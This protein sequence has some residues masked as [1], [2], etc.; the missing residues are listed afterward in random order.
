MNNIDALPSQDRGARV[1]T[2]FDTVNNIS[3]AFAAFLDR[4]ADAQLACVKSTGTR[5]GIDHDFLHG[6]EHNL[7]PYHSSKRGRLSLASD[8]GG[9]MP[10]VNLFTDDG[11]DRKMPAAKRAA[12][13]TNKDQECKIPAKRTRLTDDDGERKMHTDRLST[14]DAERKTPPFKPSTEDAERDIPAK[15]TRLT[16]DDGERKMHTDRLSTEDAERKTPPFKP[17]T[18]DGERE[19]PS[20]IKPSTEDQETK[21]L[22]VKTSTD[23]RKYKIPAESKP[24]T[25]TSSGGWVPP[26]FHAPE[27]GFVFGTKNGG[28][29]APLGDV[30][31]DIPEDTIPPFYRVLRS[32][33]PNDAFNLTS[34]N[35]DSSTPGVFPLSKLAVFGSAEQ[36]HEAFQRQ[37]VSFPHLMVKL[38]SRKAIKPNS[39]FFIVP[40]QVHA[41]KWEPDKPLLPTLIVIETSHEG[42]PPVVLMTPPYDPKEPVG[43]EELKSFASIGLA[44]DRLADRV[45]YLSRKDASV[46]QKTLYFSKLWTLPKTDLNLAIVSCPFRY[47]TKDNNGNQRIVTGTWKR[48]SYGL[49]QILNGNGLNETVHKKPLSKVI[50]TAIDSKKNEAEQ[51]IRRLLTK[52]SPSFENVKIVARVFPE[53]VRPTVTLAGGIDPNK[54]FNKFYGPAQEI[55][56]YFT[57]IHGEEYNREE[58]VNDREEVVYSDEEDDGKED[59][60]E[61]VVCGGGEEEEEDRCK[62]DDPKEQ[63]RGKEED[64]REMEDGETEDK[65]RHVEEDGTNTELLPNREDGRNQDGNPGNVLRAF[66]INDKTLGLLDP[67]FVR[68]IWDAANTMADKNQIEKSSGL[69]L[70]LKDPD[71]RMPVG[72]INCSSAAR[73]S[74]LVGSMVGDGIADKLLVYPEGIVYKIYDSSDNDHAYMRSSDANIGGAMNFHSGIIYQ[75][76]FKIDGM[77]REVQIAVCGRNMSANLE[78]NN[79]ILRAIATASGNVGQGWRVIIEA[80]SELGSDYRTSFG[81]RTEDLVRACDSVQEVRFQ[82][83]HIDFELQNDL[84]IC[85]CLLVFDNCSWAHGGKL[86]FVDKVSPQKA[87]QPPLRVSFDDH[88]QYV[89]KLL[90]LTRA[91]SFLFHP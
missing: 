47:E 18:E 3:N 33:K 74:A 82:T 22:P 24:S 85:S 16:D 51:E 55:W 90:L 39:S 25:N 1:G 42:P 48:N 67:N 44:W 59:D 32:L 9:G 86:L 23:N 70:D 41:E 17:S 77:E 20:P 83:F 11:G 79:E 12:K 62:E 65:R 60:P 53:G 28:D 73:V 31:E 69:S 36:T 84:S 78:M 14:E 49:Q 13:R 50:K 57:E 56:T 75:I 88:V 7:N 21:M 63:Y 4:D 19:T 89:A 81:H 5:D 10:A 64:D 27:G 91:Q 34:M 72:I 61:E 66:I 46:D 80:A 45:F 40:G 54:T 30:P 43:K 76:L 29:D 38:E 52:I 26:G 6:F 71:F 35:S 87:F 8:G 15:R 2:I 58:D 37:D 68:R